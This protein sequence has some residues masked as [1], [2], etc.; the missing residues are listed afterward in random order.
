MLITIGIKI[1]A[2]PPLDGVLKDH[3]KNSNFSSKLGIIFAMI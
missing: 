2:P 1:G 3:H